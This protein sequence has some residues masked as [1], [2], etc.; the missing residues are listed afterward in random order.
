MAFQAKKIF[1]IDLEPR[2]AVGISLPFS[3]EAVFNQTYQTKDAIKTNIIN[4]FLTG[5]GERYLNVKMGTSLRTLLFN[6]YSYELEE[7]IEDEIR[8]SMRRYFPRVVIKSIDITPS[9]ESNTI[10]LYIKYYISETGIEDELLI[11]FEQ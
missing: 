10:S 2:N 8:E 3:G 5:V 4:Y 6:P 7:S 11:N 9:P 1:P